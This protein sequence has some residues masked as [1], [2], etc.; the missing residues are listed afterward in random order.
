MLLTVFLFSCTHWIVRFSKTSLPKSILLLCRYLI[1]FLM[2]NTEM[3]FCIRRHKLTFWK[4]HLQILLRLRSVC[5]TG[6]ASSS[7]FWWWHGV[8][9]VVMVS[10]PIVWRPLITWGCSCLRLERFLSLNRIRKDIHP[11]PFITITNQQISN[12]ISS[13]ISSRF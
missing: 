9:K 2:A 12:Y 4:V 5:Q 6:K 8:K 11:F 3:K 7:S 10:Q 13:S 1:E